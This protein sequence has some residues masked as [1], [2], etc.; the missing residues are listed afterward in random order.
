MPQWF[1]R[2]R[3]KVFAAETNK[4]TL[5]GQIVEPETYF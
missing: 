2:V 4:L 5:R 1:A 3:A